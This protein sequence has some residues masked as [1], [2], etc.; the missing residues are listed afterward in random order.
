MDGPDAPY[1]SIS[2]LTIPL[3]ALLMFFKVTIPE[4]GE[5]DVV[6]KIQSPSTTRATTSTGIS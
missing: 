3:G 5:Y 2:S 4:P 6:L 1:W